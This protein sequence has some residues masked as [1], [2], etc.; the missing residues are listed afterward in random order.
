MYFIHKSLFIYRIYS[1]NSVDSLLGVNISTSTVLNVDNLLSSRRV[2]RSHLV[3]ASSL[4]ALVQV[5]RASLVVTILADGVEHVVQLIVLGSIAVGLVLHA[6][7]NVVH[8][9]GSRQGD[10]AIVQQV[11]TLAG[12]TVLP[13][14]VDAP[15]LVRLLV[16]TLAKSEVV[17]RII[18]NVVSTARGVNLQHVEAASAVGDLDANVIAADGARPVGYAV[19]VDVAAHDADGARVHIVRSDAGSLAALG[20]GAGRSDGS[21]RREE[22]GDLSQHCDVCFKGETGFGSKGMNGHLGEKRLSN[23]CQVG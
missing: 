13:V 2:V 5:K 8:A 17:P 15:A 23:D 16:S 14:H 21:R 7:R 19:G 3:R 1:D 10:L 20:E 4:V 6:R 11:S 18:R 9:V 22:G 12:R